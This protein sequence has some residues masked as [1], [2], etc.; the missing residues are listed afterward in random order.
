MKEDAYLGSL[1]DL[2]GKVAVVVGYHFL[3]SVERADRV[4]AEP[5]ELDNAQQSIWPCAGQPSM[6]VLRI[7]LENMMEPKKHPKR[8][9]GGPRLA[10]NPAPSTSTPWILAR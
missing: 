2:T 9:S 8:W 10:S 7:S 6:H 4:V 5:R 3:L 1:R